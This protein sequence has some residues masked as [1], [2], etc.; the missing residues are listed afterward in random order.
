M[1]RLKLLFFLLSCFIGFDQLSAQTVITSTGLPEFIPGVFTSDHEPRLYVSDYSEEGIWNVE[2][3]NEGFKSE[4]ELSLQLAPIPTRKVI[5]ESVRNIILEQSS[6]IIDNLPYTE[7]LNFV[8]GFL[9]TYEFVEFIDKDSNTINFW[10]VDYQNFGEGDMCKYVI[11]EG[12]I[13]NYENSIGSLCRYSFAWGDDNG[14]YTVISDEIYN[15]YEPS[16]AFLSAYNYDEGFAGISNASI[17][18]NIFASDKYVYM[19]PVFTLDTEPYN[20]EINQGEDFSKKIKI[21]T[22]GSMQSATEFKDE[23]GNTL[24]KIDGKACEIIKF[25]GVYYIQ[26][27]ENLGDNQYNFSFY[28]IINDNGSVRK[29][30]E[31][32]AAIYPTLVRRSEFVTV[33]TQPGLEYKNRKVIVTALDGRIM[34]KVSIPDGQDSILIDT[35]S[36]NPG[37]FNFTIFCDGK[38][39]ENGK[40]I[41]R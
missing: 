12:N 16:T 35:S 33:T 40:I 30:E 36:L 39:I 13:S 9:G 10:P 34:N 11:T 5:E 18:Q 8:Q 24:F 3:F 25:G 2:I 4:S 17:T 20:V 38:K 1:K 41:V 15:N 7:A 27:Q 32:K 21:S 26:T 29:V 6:D 23:N 28:E 22:Y 37:M 31:K 19:Y 14:E